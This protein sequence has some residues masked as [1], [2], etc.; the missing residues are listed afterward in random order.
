[1]IITST[2]YRI[3]FFGGGTDYSVWYRDHGGALLAASIN[4]YCYISCRFYP[5]FFEHRHRIVWSRIELVQNTADIQHPAVREAIQ[6]LKI[7][8]GLEIHHDGDLPAR[9][10]LGSSSAFAVGMLHALYALKGELVSKHR[11]ASEAIHLEQDLLKESVGIQDQITTAYGGL[12]LI[13]IDPSGTFQVRPVPISALRMQ[14]LQDRMLLIY[15]GIAR[16]ASQV[17]AKQI[18]SIPDKTAV[19]RRMQAM[20]HEAADILT[21]TGDL[22]DF[23]SL[24]HETWELKRSISP[25]VS[26]PMIDQLYARARQAG[27]LG[28]KLLGA[29]GGGFVLFFVEPSQRQSVLDALKDYLMV[30]FEIET[31]G[32]HIV[33]Y[34]P[35]RY[36]QF[37]RASR[38]FVR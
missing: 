22:R 2:P 23:G 20:V 11:L 24:L 8:E 9:T 27:A 34:E 17:A 33:L 29:G 26:T 5:P 28:G 25:E 13:E 35:E 38:G 12:N 31:N 18:A 32:T 14:A 21:G 1:M 6:Y 16:T 36:S 7:P 15:T 4:R 3:S 37:A 10:G 19:L 30:P